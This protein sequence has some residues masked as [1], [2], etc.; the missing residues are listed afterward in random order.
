MMPDLGLT[1]QLIVVRL[2]AGLIIFAVQGAAIAASAVRL[3]DPGPRYDGRLTLSP[4][5]HADMLGLLSITLTGFGWGLPVAIEADKLRIGRV[6][7]V[8]SVLA[9]SAAL[10]IAAYLLLLAVIPLLTF[11]PYTAGL[12]SAA[13]LRAAGRLCVF[14]ALFSLLPIPPLAGAHFLSALGISLPRHSSL[15]LGWVLLAVSIMGWTRMLLTPAYEV[16]APIVLGAA[17]AG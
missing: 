3:G 5:A 4:S 16:I 13:F 14:M 17:V 2:F 7:L 1:I 12:A 15:V 10:L 9:G 8:V 11:L 6:G